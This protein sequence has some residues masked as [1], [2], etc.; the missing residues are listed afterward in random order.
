MKRLLF[1]LIV[2]FIIIYFQYLSINANVTDFTIL[3]YQN[4]NKDMLEKILLEKRITIITDLELDK[5]MYKKNPIFMIT[6][7]LYKKL[8]EEQHTAI[9]KQLK[10]YFSYYYLPM[11]VKSDI[12]LNYEQKQTKTIL[13][14]Q[15][16]FRFCIVQF[17]GIR[18]I[19]LFPPDQFSKLYF[20]K[21]TQRFMVN[22][23]NQNIEK[24]PLVNDASYIEI[25]LY[26][27][28]AIFIPYKW[29]YCY[30]TIDN[31]MSVSFYS[32]SLFT[33]ILKI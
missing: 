21:N 31:S 33:N 11:N 22:F 26:P 16:H 17:L 18:K 12:S 1:I 20:D 15:S 25:I 14:Q 27:G 6:P 4:P 28:Q 8:S 9:L 24:Y 32:E 10:I 19:Y 23:W 13:K 7:R 29:V 2:L 3:Q 30:E 5:I